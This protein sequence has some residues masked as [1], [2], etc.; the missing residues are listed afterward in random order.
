LLLGAQVVDLLQDLACFGK[1]GK[2]C[3][4]VVIGV[5]VSSLELRVCVFFDGKSC[6]FCGQDGFSW[7]CAVFWAGNSGLVCFVVFFV[8]ALFFS[9]R[10]FD[11]FEDLF[12]FAFSC[13]GGREWR[14]GFHLFD[15]LVDLGLCQP[16]SVL[17][18]CADGK[19]GVLSFGLL[20]RFARFE[21]L[22][23]CEQVIFDGQ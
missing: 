21:G 2:G 15:E 20:V 12:V 8:S 16:S 6:C 4:C 14:K 5:L 11:V 18:V 7:C 10:A 22:G 13:F 3:L 9:E 1:T 23:C 17:P 19:R